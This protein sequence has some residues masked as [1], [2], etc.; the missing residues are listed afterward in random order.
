MADGQAGLCRHHVAL[1]VVVEWKFFLV[2]ARIPRLNMADD[3]AKEMP[4]NNK[5]AQRNPVQVSTLCSL[6]YVCYSC[7]LGLNSNIEDY[8]TLKTRQITS[9]S[10]LYY[11][12]HGGWS[13]WSVAK[14]CSVSCGSG[15]EIHA[16][17]CT[18]PAPKHG[19]KPCHGDAQKQQACTEDPCPSIYNLFHFM[20]CF[21]CEKLCKLFVKKEL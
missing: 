1:L 20:P 18:K 5:R 7:A 15:V 10:S 11:S 21:F 3:L 16:R 9:W 4:R 13:S 12:V 8:A 6:C 19:G 2:V 17:S 14:P